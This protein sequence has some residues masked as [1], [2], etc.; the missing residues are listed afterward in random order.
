MT[1]KKQAPE[2]TPAT[3]Q[4]APDDNKRFEMCGCNGKPHGYYV[5]SN[6]EKFPAVI[7]S[8]RAG[9]FVLDGPVEEGGGLVKTEDKARAVAQM[10]ASGLP[11]EREDDIEV[12]AQSAVHALASEVF[13]LEILAQ[14]MTRNK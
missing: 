13:L 14:A 12:A 1:V 9:K 7:V 10:E 2:E 3:P 5:R 11:A 4:T 6:G 8:V